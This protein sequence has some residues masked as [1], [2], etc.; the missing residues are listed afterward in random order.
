MGTTAINK[1]DHDIER[2]VLQELKWDRRLD[3][4]ELEAEVESGIVTLTG[5]V[6]SCAKKIAAGDA[7]HRVPGVMDVVNEVEVRIPSPWVKTDTELARM[8]RDALVCD[9]LVP[10]RNVKST[11]SEGWV[12]LEG[13]VDHLYQRQEAARVVESLN[14]VH[15]LTNL[16]T[17]KRSVV[18]PEQLRA[19]IEAALKR[20]SE[21]E[22]QHIEIHVKDGVLELSGKVHSWAE[23][24]AIEQLVRHAPGVRQLQ[25][26]LVINTYG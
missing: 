23:R 18:D 11:V 13:E 7:A 2:D 3:G 4:T 14:G 20:Q 1:L 25:S 21:R 17:V 5:R 19:W 12:T 6:D 16:L 9:A 10:D 26:N 8:I 15:G 22:A 24:N